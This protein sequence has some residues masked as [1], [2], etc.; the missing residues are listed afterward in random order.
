MEIEFEKFGPRQQE[1]ERKIENVET[2]VN[3]YNILWSEYWKLK[4]SEKSKR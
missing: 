2:V 4:Y 1:D 3:R